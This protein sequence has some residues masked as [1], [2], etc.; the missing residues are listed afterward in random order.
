MRNKE[1]YEINRLIKEFSS[2]DKI[3]LSGCYPISKQIVDSSLKISIFESKVIKTSIGNNLMIKGY[4][5]VNLRYISNDC[6]GKITCGKMILPFFELIPIGPC[7]DIVDMSSKITYCDIQQCSSSTIWVFNVIAVTL[8]MY[9]NK[10]NTIIHNNED[11]DSCSYNWHFKNDSYPCSNRK[12]CS[13]FECEDFDIKERC[14]EDDF[15]K[16]DDYYKYPRKK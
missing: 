14:L 7:I 11:N 2:I 6:T 8:S 16:N 1:C 5:I 10:S 9:Q 13:T 4:K 12:P 15:L 3:I